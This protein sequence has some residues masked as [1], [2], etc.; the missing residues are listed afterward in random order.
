MGLNGSNRQIVEGLNLNESDGQAM[1]EALRGGMLQRRHFCAMGKVMECDE[2]YVV[3][4]HKDWP[5]RIQAR[6]L[7][8]DGSREPPVRGTLEKEKPPIFG[9]L[10][11]SGRSASSCWRTCTEDHTDRSSRHDR[12]QHG[13]QYGRVCD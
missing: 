5:D 3:A 10:E 2:G 13:G 12:T 1:A 7:A 4:R 9:M 11:R 6:R 8:G